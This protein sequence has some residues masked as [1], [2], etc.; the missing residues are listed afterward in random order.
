VKEDFEFR[1]T[2]N[3][4]R[5]ITRGMV[6]FLAV[7]FH[8]EKNILAYFIFYAKSEK[9][10][11]AVIRHLPPN[12]PAEDI[13][14]GLVSLGFDVI[15]LKQMTTTRRSP[16]VESKITNPVSFPRNL[17]E[18]TKVPGNLPSAT[19]L[20]GWRHIEPRALSR[21]A[22]TASTSTTSGQTAN[23]HLVV[24]GAGAATCTK[25]VQRRTTLPT[26]KHAATASC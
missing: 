7:K 11:K 16:P 21:S 17:A 13:C 6:D 26:F 19:L 14:G 9:P 3:G 10:I 8:F 15:S 18:N 22:I 20:P 1:N 12:T 4:T 5:I 2:R 23:S 24:C 25:N